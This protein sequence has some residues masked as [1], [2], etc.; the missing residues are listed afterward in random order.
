M[1]DRV[2]YVRSGYDADIVVWDAHPLSIGATPRQVFID[3]VAT[4][5]PV[6]VKES[7]DDQ[8]LKPRGTRSK[9]AGEPAV[10]ALVPEGLKKDV[11]RRADEKKSLFVI[12][13]IHGSFLDNY[14][15]LAA[16]VDDVETDRNLT[17]VVADGRV[18]C[19]GASSAC[20]TEA[21]AAIQSGAVSIELSN[22]YL[23]PGLTAVTSALGLQEIAMAEETSDGAVSPLLDP[24]RMRQL[25]LR[26]VRSRAR[27]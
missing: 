25:E 3:G 24:K 21:S 15:E 2:G 7:I 11:C 17:L 26:Q 23:A 22:G 9:S 18:A 1:D 6:K 20:S 19:L 13:G 8:A 10:R 16:N 14:P 4:L 5:D 27:G 12:T